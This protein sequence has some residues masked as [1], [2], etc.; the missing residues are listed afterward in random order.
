MPA[1]LVESLSST[2]F[3][4][5][6]FSRNQIHQI[7][8]TTK[9]FKNLTRRELAHTI[10]EH[11]NWS[12]PTGSL[13]I[14][15]ALSLL[16]KF[17]AKGLC[18][19]PKLEERRSR[20][21]LIKKPISVEM[22]P[23]IEETLANIGPISLRL[24]ESKEDGERFKEQMAN[25][26]YLGYRK[27]YGAFLRYSVIDGSGRE[28]GLLLFA[29]SMWALEDRDDWIG[30]QRKHRIKRLNLVIS[31]TRFLIFPWVH[32]PNL[33]S[34]ALSLI[35]TR[36]AEDWFVRYGYRP[37]LIETFVDQEKYLGTCYQA[38]NW[39][40]VGETKGRG[41]TKETRNRQHSLK[42]IYL[43]PL[44]EN[45][46]DILLRGHGQAIKKTTDEDI[47][48]RLC[49]IHDN[50]LVFWSSVA[51]MI[52]TIAEEFDATWQKRRR[53]TD[54]MLLVLIIFRLV[55]TR[56]KKGYGSTIDEVWESCRNQGLPLPQKKP[57][58]PSTFGEGRLKLDE[59]IFKIINCR[60]LEAYDSTFSNEDFNFYGH[61][62]YAIDGSKINLPHEVISEGFKVSNEK[63]HYPQGLLS[64]L[65]RLK[66]GIPCD[67]LL[68]N[69]TNERQVSL[70]HHPALK[71]SD[72]VVYDRG[73]FSYQILRA[74]IERG[75]HGVFRLSE[76]TYTVIQKFM[77]SNETDSIVTITPGVKSAA[78]LQK[79]NVSI[80]PIELRLVRYCI[81][82]KDYFL[83]TT[84]LD[85]KY[86]HRDLQDLY[87]SRWGIEELYKTTKY[88]MATEE[89][90]SKSLRGVRQEIYAQLSLITLNRIFTNHT[91]DNHRATN[92]VAETEAKTL[93]N[94]KNSV[95]AFTRN[96][97]SL[98]IGTS[99][100]LERGLF[101]L[102]STIGARF[103]KQRP[104][105]S[106]SRVSLAPKS[107]WNNSE[108]RATAR[109]TKVA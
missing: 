91:D 75:I 78:K 94:F 83:G 26:H 99:Q 44:V 70:T 105:R 76:S 61:K 5:R 104:N 71:T 14:N 79:S 57:I 12:T 86:P 82:E 69:D 102:L 9:I 98:I 40:K 56:A 2:T 73:Y 95:A 103:Q 84:L 81:N 39:K 8:E 93:T 41:R 23:T 85:Q 90:H 101:N 100:A 16:E 28:L 48:D 62:L 32:L 27:P 25:H 72:I 97:E 65:Y 13:K 74:H 66:A 31:N 34:K 68:T 18:S 96:I 11:F 53:V 107:K 43:Y 36:I 52:R 19:L 29:S 1:D 59:N 15:S 60:V 54:S 67:F 33:A 109:T 37:V 49:R 47:R 10:C 42:D 106:Y 17:E 7:I 46:R 87:H 24:V 108:H 64:C 92:R 50:I 4:G 55:A 20:I 6:R 3:R 80:E 51:P 58:A 30:W 45:F 88:T 35:P 77:D 63:T 89:F 21:K 38:A 22:P